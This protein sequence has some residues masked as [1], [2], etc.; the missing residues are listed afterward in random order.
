ML[1]IGILSALSLASVA[2]LCVSTAQGG[3][4]GPAGPP[5]SHLH[6]D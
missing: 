5:R 2:W 1:V 3:R 6:S 4:S